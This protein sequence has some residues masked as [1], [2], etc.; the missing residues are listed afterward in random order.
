LSLVLTIFADTGS[1]FINRSPILAVQPV[2]G[3]HVPAQSL[4]L[5]AIFELKI[6]RECLMSLFDLLFN[7]R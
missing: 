3:H 6:K 4:F 1:N 5:V 2:F 7:Q